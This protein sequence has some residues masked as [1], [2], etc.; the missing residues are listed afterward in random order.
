MDSLLSPS[1][2]SV[3]VR[4]LKLFF[5]SCLNFP[6]HLYLQYGDRVEV[7][8]ARTSLKLS[9]TASIKILFLA[10][11]TTRELVVL[12]VGFCFSL[13]LPNLIRKS[14][15]LSPLVVQLFRLNPKRSYKFS[16][17]SGRE[18]FEKKIFRV[19]SDWGEL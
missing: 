2:A 7:F 19:M 4:Y 18:S 10:V 12:C 1:L 14:H 6:F 17:F 5:F 16:V 11:R 15:F 8:L 13:T 9:Q 3:A